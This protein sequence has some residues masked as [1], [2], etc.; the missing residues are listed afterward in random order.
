MTKVWLPIVAAALAVLP[1]NVLGQ[2][3]TGQPDANRLTVAR[4]HYGGGGDWYANPTSLPN[5]SKPTWDSATTTSAEVT[6]GKSIGSE[7]I[8]TSERA[9]PPRDSGP[10]D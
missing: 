8:T 1:S 5:L 9:A 2:L 10:Y 4:L 7:E 3:A 6:R